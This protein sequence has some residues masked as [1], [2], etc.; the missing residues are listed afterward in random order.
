[1]MLGLLE[2]RPTYKFRT[3]LL[4]S[5]ALVGSLHVLKPIIELLCKIARLLTVKLSVC[6]FRGKE[7]VS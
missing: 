7:L 6:L 4:S 5:L 3:V 2:F 1:M